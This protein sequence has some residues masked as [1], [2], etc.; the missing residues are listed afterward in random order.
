MAGN[1]EYLRIEIVNDKNAIYKAVIGFFDQQVLASYRNE[2]DKYTL[3]TDHFE[4]RLEKA[5]ANQSSDRLDIRFGYRT[6]TDGDLALAVFL[7]DLAA[8][9]P[10]HQARW[11][12]FHL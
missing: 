1:V 5:E 7:P 2:A 3:K 9:S 12:G 6:R 4:G 10:N 8:A 11:L